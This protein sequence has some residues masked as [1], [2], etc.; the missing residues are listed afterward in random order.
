MLHHITSHSNV[1]AEQ[2]TRSISLSAIKLTAGNPCSC[3]ARH[4]TT[5]RIFGAGTKKHFAL[6][7]QREPN[8]LLQLPSLPGQVLPNLNTFP[9]PTAR[10]G[11]RLL[12]REPRGK[13][14]STPSP[15]T[16]TGR[17]CWRKALTSSPL[18][19]GCFYKTSY[20]F[21]PQRTLKHKRER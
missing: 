8:P 18:P 17:E 7:L 10:W 13:C 15:R 1:T 19:R 6:E 2:L 4:S 21:F 16:R 5:Q 12:A 11:A 20:V 3:S 9:M 14:S